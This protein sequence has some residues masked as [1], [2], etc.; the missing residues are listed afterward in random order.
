MGIEETNRIAYLSFLRIF[1]VFFVVF[2]H[3]F[4]SYGPWNIIIIKGFSLPNLLLDIMTP[5]VAMMPFMTFLSGYLFSWLSLKGKYDGF[6]KLIKNKFS[7]LI[8]P[9]LVFGFLPSFI[10]YMDTND[11]LA[12]FDNWLNGIDHLWYLSMLFWCFLALYFLIKIK[13][14]YVQLFILIVSF[15]FMYVDFPNH[16]GFKYFGKL[17]FYFYAGYIINLYWK[18]IV[19]EFNRKRIIVLAIF[20]ISS[21]FVIVINS[22][23]SLIGSGIIGKLVLAILN[24]Y[25]RFSFL[26]LS[27]IIFY[28]LDGA[29]FLKYNKIIED[30]DS[31]SF[32][33]YIFHAFLIPVFFTPLF[34]N[35]AIKHYIVYPFFVFV[36]VLSCSYYITKIIKKT[37]IGRSLVG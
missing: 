10:I 28:K 12:F 32:G 6:L 7:R 19:L 4:C 20:L 26:L 11:K 27:V 9:M 14:K 2:W 5:F 16:L 33:I 8:I 25:I 15:C 37:K 17:F 31:C 22:Y 29:G 23:L 30:L 34:L 1:G 24:N 36:I 35:I 3:S 18:S 13:S 21:L